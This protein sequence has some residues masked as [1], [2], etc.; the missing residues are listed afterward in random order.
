MFHKALQR[1]SWVALFALPAAHGQVQITVAPAAVRMHIGNEQQFTATVTG[2]T[3]RAVNWAVNGVAGGNATVGRIAANGRYT[4]PAALPSPPEMRI[5]AVHQETGIASAGAV[6]SLLNPYPMLASVRPARLRSG[7]F[8]LTI[9]G[10]GFVTGC[11]VT[12]GDMNLD[13]AFVTPTRLMASGVLP[14]SASGRLPL[15]VTNP[16]PGGKTSATIMVEV[17]APGSFSPQVTAGAAARFLEQAAF[18]PDRAS[19]EQVQRLGF[20]G[21]ID[22]QFSEPISPYQN[23]E[24]IGLGLAPLQARFFT[25]AVHGGDQ[26]R[27]RVAFAL[28]QIWVVSGSVANRPERFVPYLRLLQRD[29]FGNYWTLMWETT[30]CPAMGDYLNLVNNAKANPARGALPNENYAR[31]LLQLFTVG[32]DL[33][34]LDGTYQLDAAGKRIPTYTQKDIQ[35][36]SRA[37][38]GWTYP[39]RPGAAPLARNPAY[40]AAP[41]VPW[42][43]NHDTDPKVLLRGAEVPGW[44]LAEED[45]ESVVANL[46]YHPNIAPFVSKNLIQHLVKSN[47][48]P[49]YVERVSRAFEDNPD[50][51]GDLRQVIRAILLDPEARAGDDASQPAASDGHLR[52]PA[53]WLASLLRALEATVNDTNTLAGRGSALGQNVHYPPTVFNYYMPGFQIPGTKLLGP[54]FQILTPTTALNRANQVNAIIYGNLGAGTYI[55]L[56]AWASLANSPNELMDRIEVVFFRGQMP[57]AMRSVILEAVIGAAGER[58]KAQA[59]LYLAASSGYY[60]VSR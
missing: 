1:L 12:L 19:I 40:Y 8:A 44:R 34:N 41:M 60:A 55:D 48:S 18:G 24:M 17:S 6:V 53:L 27:Q 7:P 22:A 59:A 37:L 52:E 45:L 28:A 33:L 10:S 15:W 29:A 57:A 16:E 58:A 13:T 3:N 11:R 56:N 9:N 49:A 30:L 4:S 38:T 46:F 32:T 50:G 31:E 47:P 43:A 25:N 35:E 26:L 36:F 20:S 21:W 23:P 5:T 39:T 51:R 14:E 42:E 54:E 2:A